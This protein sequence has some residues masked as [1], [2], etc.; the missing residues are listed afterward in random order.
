MDYRL[1]VAMVSVSNVDNTKDFYQGLGW[2]LDADF[3]LGDDVHV[4]QLTPPGSA[5][6]VSSRRARGGRRR[7]AVGSHRG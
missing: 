7:C 1:E 4:V 3:N 6:S 5:C 2:R